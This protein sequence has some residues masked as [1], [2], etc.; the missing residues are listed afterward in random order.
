MTSFS[1]NNSILRNQ[2]EYINQGII[3]TES[4]NNMITGNSVS[5]CGTGISLTNSLN[6]TIN[7]NDVT[8]SQ[9][10]GISLSYSEDN[11]IY[12]N[13]FENIN[14][15]YS[16]ESFCYWD[17]GF[18]SGGNYWSDYEEKYPMAEEIDSSGIWNEPYQIIE[19]EYDNFPLINQ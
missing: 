1:M 8:Y 2:I 16:Y 6:N 5:N 3:L 10:I 18:P 15:V 14:Q 4:P 9:Q 7:E 12:H 13:V 17:N 19:S 11:Y